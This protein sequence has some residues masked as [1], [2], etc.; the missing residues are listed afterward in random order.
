MDFEQKEKYYAEDLVSIMKLLRE[1]GGC[2]WDAEQ[3]HQSIRKNFIEETYEVLEAIDTENPELLCE[4]LGDVMLQIVFH[5]QMEAEKGVFDFSD[6]TDGICRK[7]IERHPHVFGEVSV[8]NSDEVLVNWDAIK[9]KT[10]NQKSVSESMNS[11]PKVFPALMRSEK[12]QSKA[13]KAGFDWNDNGEGAFEKLSEETNE[14]KAAAESGSHEDIEE[15]LGDVLF[16]AVNIS[17]FLKCD[18]E[19]ALTKATDKFISRFTAVENAAKEKGIDMQ[20]ASLEQLDELWNEAK[21]KQ[22]K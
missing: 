16:S 1:P 14:L 22:S 21:L 12:I 8:A 4:E 6:V 7:L 11:V 5:A 20:T 2:P 18:P 15:E 19:E 10:K 3:N 13:R 9:R 17:S